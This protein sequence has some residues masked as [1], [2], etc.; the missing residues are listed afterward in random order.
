MVS[1]Q[2]EY[3][4]DQLVHY[5]DVSKTALNNYKDKYPDLD[6]ALWQ[7]EQDTLSE[8]YGFI[9]AFGERVLEINAYLDDDEKEGIEVGTV[10]HY[11]KKKKE[12]KILNR[13][14]REKRLFMSD[15]E[16][17]VSLHEIHLRGLYLELSALSA[18]FTAERI[19]ELHRREQWVE[20]Q[21]QYLIKHYYRECRKYRHTKMH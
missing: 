10:V 2:E 11:Q 20:T 21:K 17:L 5:Y 12:E 15:L 8:L 1:P 4:Y 6:I 3:T 13:I 14:S 18:K 16:D 19:Q 7:S 9:T